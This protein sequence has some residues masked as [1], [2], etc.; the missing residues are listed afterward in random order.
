MDR[1]LVAAL[2]I[3]VL[4]AAGCQTPAEQ[5][6]RVEKQTVKADTDGVQR[7]RIVA[8]SYFF[9]PNRIVVRANVPVELAASR[10]GADRTAN[11]TPFA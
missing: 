11:R 6:A 7:V 4:A 9:K 10:E 8:G 3:A 1:Y 5:P 2:A